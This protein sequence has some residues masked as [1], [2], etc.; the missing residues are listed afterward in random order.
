MEGGAMVASFF[1][2]QM[3]NW[4]VFYWDIF[5]FSTTASKWSH[6]IFSILY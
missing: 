6:A 5:S 4:W 1:P 3:S 2:A